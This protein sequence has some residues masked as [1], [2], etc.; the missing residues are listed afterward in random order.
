MGGMNGRDVPGL[1]IFFDFSNSMASWTPES[2]DD[3][4]WPPYHP[5]N[6]NISP[7]S[8]PT[9]FG[10][11]VCD[12]QRR[13]I[14]MSKHIGIL[15]VAA[16]LLLSACGSDPLDR[17]ASGTLIGAGTGAAI[18]AIAAGPAG[19]A[20]GAWVGAASGGVGGAVTSPS[21]VNLGQPVWR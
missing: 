13:V 21:M 20:F 14:T 17:A 3:R 6:S 16:G 11:F 10:S 12:P 5:A 15:V 9:F 7:R 2:L 19:A 1:W 18:G 8:A 4:G